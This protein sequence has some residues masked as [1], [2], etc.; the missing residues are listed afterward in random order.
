LLLFLLIACTACAE[1]PD[2]EMN[3]AQGAIAA[4]EAAG[5]AQYASAE[6]AAATDAL[7]KS[8]EAVTQ[9]DY[10]LAL[11]LA[12]DSRE[13]AQNAAK[14]AVDGRSKARG[15]AER[16]IAEVTTLLTQA[17]DR[18]QDPNVSKLPRRTT[19]SAH[20]VIETADKRMQEARAAL[21]ADDYAQVM[22]LTD[23]LAAQLRAILAET[24]P[25]LAPTPPKKRR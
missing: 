8:E 12:I 10:R 22:K 2:K 24:R 20:G 3:Q 16:A 14:V 17:R 21:K 7:K 19:D 4:A 13:R 6:L 5:A 9:R 25:A 15:D 18:L 1:P 23:G 11:S